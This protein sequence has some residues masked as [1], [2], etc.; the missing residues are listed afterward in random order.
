M[1]SLHQSFG[2]QAMVDDVIDLGTE[3]VLQYNPYVENSPFWM[4]N[5][6]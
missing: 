5:K 4:K 1:D 2:P 6:R 3:D